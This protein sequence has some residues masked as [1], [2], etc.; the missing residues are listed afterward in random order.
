[1]AGH[2]APP[3][4]SQSLSVH[5]NGALSRYAHRNSENIGRYEGFPEVSPIAFAMLSTI[6]APYAKKDGSNPWTKKPPSTAR[7]C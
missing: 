2:R 7:S 4:S 3:L 6:E 1:M 5:S